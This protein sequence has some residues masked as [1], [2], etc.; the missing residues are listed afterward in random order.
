[1]DQDRRD[2]V[3]ELP[4]QRVKVPISISHEDCSVEREAGFGLFEG[5]FVDILDSSNAW[6]D[7][8][9][10]IGVAV[11]IEVHQVVFLSCA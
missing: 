6:T 5:A 8:S 3:I 2:W 1:M 4:D 7:Q 10:A 11:T 9:R